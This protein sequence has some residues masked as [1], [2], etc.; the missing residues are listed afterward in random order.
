LESEEEKNRPYET[1]IKTVLKERE[2]TRNC[3]TNGTKIKTHFIYWSGFFFLLKLMGFQ[4][5]FT[6]PL[7]PHLKEPPF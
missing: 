3:T 2:S 4:P 1:V 7:N 5:I 6:S